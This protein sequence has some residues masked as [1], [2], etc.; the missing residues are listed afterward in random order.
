MQTTEKSWPAT[1]G[2]ENHA[3]TVFEALAESTK[4]TPII[5]EEDEEETESKSATQG[6]VKAGGL[7]I[8]GSLT[9][10]ASDH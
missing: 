5:D 3:L 2:L 4:V 7:N 6:K 1:A 8:T 9:N 10:P